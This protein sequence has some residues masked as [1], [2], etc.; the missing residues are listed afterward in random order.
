[1]KPQLVI[2]IVVRVIGM[3]AAVVAIVNTRTAQG[4]TAWAV[5]L[6]SYPIVALPVYLL[7]GFDRFKGYVRARRIDDDQARKTVNYLRSQLPDLRV[8]IAELPEGAEVYEK[9][10]SLPFLK[11]NQLELLIDGHATFESIFAALDTAEHYILLQFYILRGDALGEKL[12]HKLTGARRRG[13][14]V[15]VLYDSIGSHETKKKFYRRMQAEGIDCRPF[16]STKSLRA[17]I[18]ANFRNHRK[19]VIVDGHTA[20]IGGHNVGDEYLG[21]DPKM[22]HWRDTHA[23][24]QGPAV[25]QAQM[26]FLEDWYWTTSELPRLD[27]KADWFG[28][29]AALFLAAGP[30]DAFETCSAMYVHAVNSAKKR[31]WIATPYFIPNPQMQE[32]LHLAVLRGVDTRLVVAGRSDN[33]ITDYAAYT[34]VEDA[35]RAGVKVGWY[36]TG[37]N[38]QK[39]F[40]T[41]DTFAAVSTANCDPR[42]FALNF[43]ETLIVVDKNFNHRVAEMLQKDFDQS[44]PSD[45]LEFE[46]PKL[47]KRVATR[48][49]RLLSPL[50]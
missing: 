36:M 14:K 5:S 38:H 4:A 1:M 49:A 50:L 33:A 41:D 26:A 44:E 39:T 23:R 24:I 45:L 18:Q 12:F 15:Y 25:L 42:S 29:A 47:I 13:V 32:A 8:P 43:E 21:L 48:T 19:M 46:N 10:A 3:A 20:F 7:F 30:A 40:L 27:W 22:G 11:G 16:L 35:V 34:Y 9:L 28:D 31:V 2:E 6:L 37:F 17:R